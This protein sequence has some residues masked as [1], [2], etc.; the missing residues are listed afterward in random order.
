MWYMKF[1]T[2]IDINAPAPEVWSV[3]ADVTRWPDWTPTMNEVRLLEGDRLGAAGSAEVRQPKLPKAVWKVTEFDDGR[4]FAW[5]AG[6]P[7]VHTVGDH[8]VE[9]LG[10][11]RCRVR[12]G[13]ETTGAMSR[14]FWLFAGN[15]TRR[16]VT[17]EADSLKRRCEARST[18]AEEVTSS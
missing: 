15:L 6:G 11:D 18:R 5:A 1:E 17:L 10:A 14:L 16:Y 12:L 2:T 9:P 3:L 13:I 8:V 7:G 4:R